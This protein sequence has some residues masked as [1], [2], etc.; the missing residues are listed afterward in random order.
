MR[1]CIVLILLGLPLWSSELATTPA[2]NFLQER[3]KRDPEDTHALNRLSGEYMQRLRETGDTR[4]LG[5]AR[6]AAKQ[7]LLV[8][9][10]PHNPDGLVAC[11]V[12]CQA[13]HQ[14]REAKVHAETLQGLRP[15]KPQGFELRGDAAL[16]LNELAIAEQEFTRLKVAAGDTLGLRVRLARLARLRGDRE[17]A[18]I[19]YNSAVTLAQQ[20]QPLSKYW[21]AWALVQRGADYFSR[22]DVVAATNDYTEGLQTLPNAWFALDRMGELHAMQGRWEEAEVAYRNAIGQSPAPGLKHALG[23]VLRA[24][25]KEAAAAEMFDGAEAGYLASAKAGESIFFHHLA[26]FYADSKSNPV[27]AERWAR[28]DLEL[29]RTPAS[30]DGLAW[31]LYGQ[32]KFLEAATIALEALAAGGHHGGDAHLLYHAGMI[33]MR[34]DNLPLGRATLRRAKEIN[35][36]VGGFHIHR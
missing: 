8:V 4:W 21:L 32:G 17:A 36:G 25:G 9:P 5:M 3:V 12:V 18:M 2:I 27:E 35:P 10:A 28:R 23:E 29:R 16:E 1:S 20:A 30:M 14:F 31:A 26:A 33:L 34:A 24:A 7:S 22:G 6:D 15:G 11:A 19:H 13:E